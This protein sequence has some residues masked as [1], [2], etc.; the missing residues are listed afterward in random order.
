MKP[1]A[2]GSLALV[3]W[4]TGAQAQTAT[5]SDDTANGN[6]NVSDDAA[7]V[8][9]VARTLSTIGDYVT[10]PLRWKQSEWLEFG[11]AAAAIGASHAEDTRVRE[12]FVG[13]GAGS[14]GSNNGH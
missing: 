3:L 4:A 14:L 7:C 2:I 8:T 12:H 5:A 11:L 9:P 6:C 13:S 10:S 1:L